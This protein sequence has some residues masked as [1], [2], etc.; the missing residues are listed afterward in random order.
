MPDGCD[1][2]IKQKRKKI[3]Q[4]KRWDNYKELGQRPVELQRRMVSF[5]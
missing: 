4:K 3:T 5:V 2:P 1:S